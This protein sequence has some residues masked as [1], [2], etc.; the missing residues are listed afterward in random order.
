MRV[1]MTSHR[2]STTE[3]CWRT[4]VLICTYRVLV[5]FPRL[6]LLMSP[7]FCSLW[8]SRGGSLFYLRHLLSLVCMGAY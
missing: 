8:G 6:S 2:K 1:L 5:P 4:V 3:V 7:I